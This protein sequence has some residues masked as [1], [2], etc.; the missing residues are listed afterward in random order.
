M[1]MHEV[2]VTPHNSKM[3][4]GNPTEKN[5]P[6]IGGPGT[7]DDHWWWRQAGVL[8]ADKPKNINMNAKVLYSHM[9]HNS[10]FSIYEKNR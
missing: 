3:T 10:R 4:A 8:F 7:Q 2:W 1:I 9:F 6:F 5:G